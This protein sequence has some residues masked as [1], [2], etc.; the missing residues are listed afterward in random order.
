MIVTKRISIRKLLGFTRV[1]LGFLLGFVL[2]SVMAYQ[3]MDLA[4]L[5]ALTYA[6]GFLG[7]A[8]AFLIGFRNNNA[9]GRWW[10][11]Q[12]LWS[13]LKYESRAFAS[14][15]L[16]LVPAD[17][18]RRQTREQL[19]RRQAAFAWRLNRFLRKLP[20]GDEIQ[21]LLPAD[22]RQA[23]EARQTPP[24]ALL[25]RQN[26]TVRELFEAGALDSYK[27][28]QLSQRL[29]EFQIVLS[30]CERLKKT[31]F[32]MQYSWFMTYSLRLF[33][34]ILPLSLAGHLGYWSVPLSLLIGYAFIML[35]YVGRY[36]EAP[37]ENGVNDVPM[38]YIARTIEIDLLEMLG[39]EELP[40][41][42]K[43]VGMG[44]LY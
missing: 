4:L 39:E 9:Y 1:N 35:E 36:V 28:V 5:Q 13:K 29:R 3:Y 27:H 42:V 12:Q 38:D 40:E 33:L 21:S 20:M 2:L 18:T 32:P 6:S 19:I 44:Y 23:I 37:F 11:G 25:N 14:L 34:F 24:L 22:E 17:E 16:S 7:T 43:P 41:P 31:P 10:E 26:E 8:L 15:V 30:G